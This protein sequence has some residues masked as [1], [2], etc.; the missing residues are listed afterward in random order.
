MCTVKLFRWR[1]STE[2]LQSAITLAHTLSEGSTELEEVRHSLRILPLAE[3]VTQWQILNGGER[4]ASPSPGS[5]QTKQRRS[6]PYGR[7]FSARPS[8]PGGRGAAP[9]RLPAIPAGAPWRARLS[10]APFPDS[11]GL[12]GSIPPAARPLPRRPPCPGD[13]GHLRHRAHP[14]HLRSRGSPGGRA[15]DPP[16]APRSPARNTPP[17]PSPPLPRSGSR[18][19]PPPPAAAHLPTR[20]AQP[21]PPISADKWL[22]VP[23]HCPLSGRRGTSVSALAPPRPAS[24]RG[25][26]RPSRLATPRSR[27]G[28]GRA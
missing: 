19:A 11:P 26:P 4:S 18:R 10:R 28:R 2:L 9:R 16:P 22:P 7:T 27:A 14:E 23:V 20:A 24:P 8:V 12:R 5:Q 1:G 6:P 13:L 21:P 17:P 15:P 25:W 3:Q